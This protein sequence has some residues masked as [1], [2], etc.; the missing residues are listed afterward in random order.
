MLIIEITLW[1]D[2]G[3][4]SEANYGIN[5]AHSISDKEALT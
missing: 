3:E 4:L 2:S 1:K 5:A